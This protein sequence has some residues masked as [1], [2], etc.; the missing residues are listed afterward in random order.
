ML[1]NPP[2]LTIYRGHRRPK[3]ALIEAFRGTPTFHLYDA[4]VRVGRELPH[5]A[6]RRGRPPRRSASPAALVVGGGSSWP[7]ST[8][9]IRSG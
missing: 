9:L 7:F 1:H 4:I 3:K 6:D 8:V 2:L 5:Q